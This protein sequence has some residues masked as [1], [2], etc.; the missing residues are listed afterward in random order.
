ML[1]SKENNKTLEKLQDKFL[2]KM[3]DRGIIESYLLSPLSKTTNPESISQFKMVRDPQSNGVNDLLIH[4][5]MP[6][7]LHNNLLTFPDTDKNSN[8]KEIF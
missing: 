7:S 6:V 3:I 2:E 8:Y 1:T 5:T 4:K